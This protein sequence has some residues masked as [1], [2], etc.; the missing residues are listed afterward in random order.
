MPKRSYLPHHLHCIIAL[1]VVNDNMTVD[2][3]NPAPL[4]VEMRCPQLL[5]DRDPLAH[6]QINIV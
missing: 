2:G 6:P 4:E 1:N 5:N 3:N